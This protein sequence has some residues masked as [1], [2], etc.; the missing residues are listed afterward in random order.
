MP[1]LLVLLPPEAPHC[2]A[3]TKF[4]AQCR[5]AQSTVKGTVKQKGSHPKENPVPGSV[6]FRFFWLPCL[7][8]LCAPLDET[9]PGNESSVGCAQF[10]SIPPSRHPRLKADHAAALGLEGAQVRPSREKQRALRLQRQCSQLLQIVQIQRGRVAVG[11]QQARISSCSL[12]IP[13]HRPGPG[14]PAPSWDFRKAAI[15]ARFLQS[16]QPGF[17]SCSSPAGLAGALRRPLATGLPPS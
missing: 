1:R 11:P 3:A 8:R 12:K 17:A 7:V 5:D 16:V 14:I 13:G 4:P 10:C 9:A 2:S 6:F 15:A